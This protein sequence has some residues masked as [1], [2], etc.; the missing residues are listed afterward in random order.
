MF[1]DL[2]ICGFAFAVTYGYAVV[3]AAGV[4]RVVGL[5]YSGV[6]DGLAV[7]SS[8]D[9]CNES[10]RFT[11]L[12]AEI[13]DLDGQN[14]GRFIIAVIVGQLAVQRNRAVLNIQSVRNG[15]RSAQRP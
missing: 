4:R 2:S 14:A 3:L 11:F 8:I 1:A 5:H 12:N 9:H 10:Y 13:T 6:V 15:I 7:C